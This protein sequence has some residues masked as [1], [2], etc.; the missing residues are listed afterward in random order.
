MQTADYL[1]A[2]ETLKASCYIHIKAL[3]GLLE[4]DA[5]PAHT[6]VPHLTESYANFRYHDWST[7]QEQK[8]CQIG[9]YN[10]MNINKAHLVTNGTLQ[11]CS[12]KQIP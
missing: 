10:Y 7:C 2:F 5:L 8:N 3:W 11:I 1:K 6:P 9:S 4:Q 12:G